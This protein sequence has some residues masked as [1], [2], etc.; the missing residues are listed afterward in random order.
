MAVEQQRRRATIGNPSQL[1][2]SMAAP[3]QIHQQNQAPALGSQLAG[4]IAAAQ[5]NSP[6]HH[7]Q[8]QMAN[9]HHNSGATTA[10]A[11]MNS[12]PSIRQQTPA[13]SEE[14]QPPK[15]Q[16]VSPTNGVLNGQQQQNEEVQVRQSF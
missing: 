9:E 2:G 6:M 15:L 5:R 1:F 11:T 16:R 14:P 8:N 12:S 4:L 10:N 7:H 3:Q 13:G